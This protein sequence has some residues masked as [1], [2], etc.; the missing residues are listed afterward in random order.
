MIPIGLYIHAPFCAAKC[1]YCDF[2]SF[3]GSEEAMDAYTDAL[4]RE[5]DAWGASGALRADTVYFGGGTPSLLGG[6]RLARILERA[7]VRFSLPAGAEVTLEANPADQLGP[8]L[9]AARRAGVNRLSLGVQS[10]VPSELAALGRRH[11]LCDAART[12]E[13]AARAGI[14]NLSVDLML[15][16]PGQTMDSLGASIEFLAGLLPAHVSAYLLKIEEGTPFFHRRDSLLLPDEDTAADLYLAA[17]REL[18]GRG[19]R[20]YEISNFARPGRE[21]RHNLK[22]WN[23]AP[24]L[25]LG[26]S[27]HSF[28]EG[29]RFYYPRDV[30][31]YLDG[32]PDRDRVLERLGRVGVA[33]SAGSAGPAGP[34]PPLYEG[35]G[36]SPAE[37]A[38]LRFRLAE[39]LDFRLFRQK[40][41]R[42]PA[43]ELFNRAARYVRAGY[44]RLNEKGLC[45]T[46]S[47]FLLSNPILAD[48]LEEV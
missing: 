18:E 31:A 2:Y 9:E 41:G 14:D 25:G 30:K 7:A 6:R 48:L 22:Y 10:G 21:S 26:P 3:E 35:E 34:V 11:S 13:D 23:A 5:L 46:P 47:G 12:A 16:I 1:A 15:A 42:P 40:Y 19:W 29:V 17:V 44:M 38:M 24:Y 28:L 36:G 37:Y 33:G 43:D 4:I 20:Q 45:L 32:G 39:G 8:T 27:A